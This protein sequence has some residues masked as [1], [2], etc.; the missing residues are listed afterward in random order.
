MIKIIIAGNLTII[1]MITMITK[2][3]K[4]SKEEINI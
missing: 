2:T 1:K 3:I 4:M